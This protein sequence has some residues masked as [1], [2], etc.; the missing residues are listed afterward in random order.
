MTG[1]TI[2]D[3]V[4]ACGGT[5][6]GDNAALTEEITDIVTDSRRAAPGC[7]F[8]AIAGERVDGHDFIPAA[9]GAGALCSICSKRDTDG[10]RIVVESVPAAL[11]S[12][13]AEYRGRFSIPVV[14][15]TGSVGKT[16]TK[17]MV[18][19]VLSQRFNT[20]KTQGNFNNELGVPLTLFGLDGNHEAAVVEMGISHFGE[21]DRLAGMV[22]P[23]VALISNIGFAHLEFLG[24]RAGVLREK[25]DI[26]SHSGKESVLIVN[27]D[28]DMLSSYDAGVQKIS[29]GVEDGCNVRAENVRAMGLDGIECEIVI[30]DRRIG[31]RIPSFGFHMVSAALA[32]AAVG[33]YFGL[34]DEEIKRGIENYKAVGR[35]SSVCNT[36]LYTLIDDCYNSNPTSLASS[37]SSIAMLDSRRVC[38]LGDMKELGEGARDL[39]REMGRLCAKLG[40]SLL[41][42]CGEL[43]ECYGEGAMQE[44][45]APVVWH[46]PDREE[47]IAMLPHLLIKGDAILVKA[48]N[49]MGFDKI[50][51]AIKELAVE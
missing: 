30:G 43:S 10:N 22:R 37:L 18:W 35:R 34:S 7:I 49:S 25:A 9:L 41:I 46:F 51:E 14:G 1:F 32:G 23:D 20:L 38:I 44:E 28:D 26:L 16:T 17:E 12:I 45:N 29:Y 36:G 47:L 42:T 40:M 21:M 15:I 39:H 2:K 31:V 13:A 8:A 11:Q 19:S 6:F 24:D 33:A 48:S 27:G 50:S 5:Y 3:V 4:S